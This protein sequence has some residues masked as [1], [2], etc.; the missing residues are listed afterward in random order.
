MW[1]ANELVN[2]IG[3]TAKCLI[4]FSCNEDPQLE[5]LKIKSRLLT[6]SI[7][8]RLVEAWIGF[9]EFIVRIVKDLTFRL[10]Q[11]D[12]RSNLYEIK[13]QLR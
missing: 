1:Q 10:K 6:F 12:P 11:A 2:L 4:E 7:R 9:D 3:V 13:F 5:L 8:K